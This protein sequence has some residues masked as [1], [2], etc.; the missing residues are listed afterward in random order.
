M[1]LIWNSLITSELRTFSIFISHLGISFL[2]FLFKSLV[3]FPTVVIS[4]TNLQK[5]LIHSGYKSVVRIIYFLSFCD[6]HF[7]SLMVFLD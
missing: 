5:F 2:N 6:L 1:P 3:Y 7:H 4:L